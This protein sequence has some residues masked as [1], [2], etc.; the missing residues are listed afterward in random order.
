MREIKL[1]ICYEPPAEGSS[2]D[3]LDILEQAEF[4]RNN[5][6]NCDITLLPYKGDT[7]GYIKKLNTMDLAWN[8]FET[9]HGREERQH[10][11]AA[12][13]ELAG[14]RYTGT[15]LDTLAVC[16][17]KRRVKTFLR[18]AGLPTPAMYPGVFKRCVWIVK[19]SSLHGSVG[20]TDQ[21][22]LSPSSEAE[23]AAVID[24]RPELALFAEEYIDGDEY[25]ATILELDGA[26]RTI[27]V[28]RMDFI[29]YPE[30]KPKILGF[31]AKWD[32]GSSDYRRT[33]RSFDVNPALADI[34]KDMADKTS[35]V[36]GLA[37][38]AR[39]DFRVDSGGTPW[40]IDVNP[41]PGIGEDAGFIAACRHAGM[42]VSGCL[43]A[44]VKAALKE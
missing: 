1:A 10:L 36:M 44:V 22:V 16:A 13:L 3:L 34:I 27:A 19:P 15:P 41:N 4:L 32:E 6:K 29:G 8:L 24:S 26:P 11:G 43:E 40:I 28:A 14:V 31:D 5:I 25:S 18:G 39:I 38:F 35:R 12:L 33:V 17:D 9:F 2:A 23:L 7:A 20:I 21:S 42:S 37:G 30:G